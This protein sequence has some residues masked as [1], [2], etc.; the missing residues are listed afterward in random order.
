MKKNNLIVA[1]G[2]LIVGLA[3]AP[4][5]QAQQDTTRKQSAGEVAT[6]ATYSSLIA[7][8]D[9]SSDNVAKLA[10]L[11]SLTPE[12]VRIVNAGPL[13]EGKNDEFKAA[14]DK[15]NA[16][17]MQLREAI[18]KNEAITNALAAH[19]QK[20]TAADVVAVDVGSDGTVQVFYH[21]PM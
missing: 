2:T 15:N 18:G 21:R 6:T 14:L 20:L 9:A 4:S 13:A 11:T 5:V 3:F 10:A 7:A 8:L 19:D 16:G 12:N 1:A 17:I